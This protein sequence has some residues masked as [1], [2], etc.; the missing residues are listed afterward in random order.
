MKEKVFVLVKGIGYDY[1]HCEFEVFRNR[2][3]ANRKG[4]AHLEESFIDIRLC[5]TD[6]PKSEVKKEAEKMSIKQLY[7]VIHPMTSGTSMPWFVVYQRA[8]K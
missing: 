2:K 8:I 4:K 7:K 1:E 3:D 6:S 5:E